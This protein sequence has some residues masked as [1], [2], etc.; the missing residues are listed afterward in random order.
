MFGSLFGI[1]GDVAK[2]VIAP[3][4]IVLDTTRIITKPLGDMAETVAQEVKQTVKDLTE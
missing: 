1:V 3:V 2:I 4:E